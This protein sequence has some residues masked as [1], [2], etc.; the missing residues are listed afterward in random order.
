MRKNITLL[1]FSCASIYTY[2]QT[3]RVGINTE[4]PQN[5]FH[6]DGNKDNPATGTPTALQQVNDVI[7]TNAG[8]IGIGTT[9]PSQNLDVAIGNARV[10]NINTNIGDAI[11]DK[12]VVADANGVLK[13][14]PKQNSLIF[15]GDLSDAVTSSTLTRPALNSTATSSNLRTVNFTVDYTSLVTLD[16][17]ISYNIPNINDLSDGFV[18]S[19][20]S[21][22]TF[23]SSATP[24]VPTGTIFAANSIPITTSSS[25]GNLPGFYYLSGSQTLRLNPGSYQLNLFGS[26]R[27]SGVSSVPFSVEFGSAATD[28]IT[29]TAKAV[30]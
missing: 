3:G 24:S 26:I 23:S 22:F 7:V 12:I 17:T 28:F 18:R 25:T 19:L 27:N 16:Y 13:T 21:G 5:T 29:I 30:Q 4:N 11:T 6:I 9:T 1:L 14:I 15:G 20:S 2:S 8:Q 10:R